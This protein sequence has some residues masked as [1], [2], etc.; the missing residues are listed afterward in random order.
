MTVF[1][2]DMSRTIVDGAKRCSERRYR[3]N[4]SINDLSKAP[5]GK[6][7]RLNFADKK[8]DRCLKVFL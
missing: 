2:R 8:R 5:N 1:N 3:S 4:R 7:V 6:S